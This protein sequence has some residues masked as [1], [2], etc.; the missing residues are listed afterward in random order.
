MGVQG[1]CQYE[2][3]EDA[4]KGFHKVNAALVPELTGIVTIDVVSKRGDA[5]SIVLLALEPESSILTARSKLDASFP[6]S[7]KRGL[8]AGAG[9]QNRGNA[10]TKDS[11]LETAELVF[12]A[13]GLTKVY[14]SG[15]AEVRAL[16]GVDLDLFAGELIVLLGPSGSGK[17]TL[18]NQLG[19]LDVPTDG[20]LRIAILT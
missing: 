1:T 14:G 16:A 13:R 18:L 2:N 10:V 12:R 15:T 11:T 5:T 20:E 4:W 8:R 7:L 3:E 9:Q 6:S 19:G 17:T